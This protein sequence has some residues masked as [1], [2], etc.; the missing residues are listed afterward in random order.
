MSIT[1]DICHEKIL[2]EMDF[3]LAFSPEKDFEKWREEVREKLTELL[4]NMP[5]K[6][7]LNIRVEW[8]KEHDTFLEK[9]IIFTSEKH[10]DVPCHLWIPKEAEKPCPAL[11]CL[12]GHSTGMHISMGRVVY[13]DDKKTIAGGDRDFAR[14][15]VNQGYAALC[16]EQ[17]A[18]GERRSEAGDKFVKMHMPHINTTCDH[19]AHTA[20]LIGRTLIGERVW[21]VCRAIDVL[22]AI[23]EI[24]KDKIGVMGN[25]GG[26]T[27][28]YYS[29]CMEPRIKAVMPSCSV[30]SFRDSIAWKHHCA[31]NYIPGIAQYFDMGELAALIAPRPLVVVAGQKDDGFHIDGVH[32]V[33]KTI[34]AIYSKAGAENNCR[35]IAGSEGHRF[36]AA[37]SWE[38]F[39]QLTGWKSN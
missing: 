30:C 37:P 13:E 6:T 39:N 28:A 1:I 2:E 21:D 15:I 7:D 18:F 19:A 36:Y 33:Y 20:M 10:I 11:I 16:V 32:K 31:C 29:A 26:G 38:V 4:G 9:R 14:Q 34:E 5:E 27:A 8:E 3:K 23:P 17:R 24:N 35:L 12:Q 22:E 25:S